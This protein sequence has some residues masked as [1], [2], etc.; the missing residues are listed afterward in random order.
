[1]NRALRIANTDRYIQRQLRIAHSRWGDSRLQNLRIL[2]PHRNAKLSI[3]TCGNRHCMLCQN[4]RKRGE[5]TMQEK[6]LMQRAL[7]TVE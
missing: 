2:Q 5:L 1:M 3:S 4:P 6:R 7:D